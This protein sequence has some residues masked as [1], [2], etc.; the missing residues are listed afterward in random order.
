MS[1]NVIATRRTVS[2]VWAWA[3]GYGHAKEEP[4][5]ASIS[6]RNDL[7]CNASATTAPV[8]SA[9]RVCGLAE[10]KVGDFFWN[11]AGIFSLLKLFNELLLCNVFF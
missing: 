9:V 5:P 10:R 1:D 4:A 2:F 11:D 6:F 7:R 3:I 8:T